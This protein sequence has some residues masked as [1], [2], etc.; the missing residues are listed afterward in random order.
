MF[1]KIINEI[2]KFNKIAIFSHQKSDGDAIG[3]S[4]ALKLALEKLGKSVEIFIQKPIHRNFNFLGVQNYVNKGGSEKFDL[5]IS[6]D[7]PNSKRIGLYEKKFLSIKNSIAIDHHA[8]FENFAD[9]NYCDSTT[10]ST[11]LIIF[12]LITKMNI[13]LDKNIALCLYSGMATDTG[14]FNHGNMTS[15]LFEAVAKLFQ[16][17]VNF[18]LA[19]YIL[20]KRQSKNEFNLYK[21]ALNKLQLFENDKIAIVMLLSNDFAS[22]NTTPLDTFRIIDTITGIETVKLACVLSQNDNE[23]FFVSI[24]SRDEFSAQNVAKEFGGGGHIR[25]SGC[26]IWENSQTALIQVVE[27]CKKEIKRVKK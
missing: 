8:D 18:D 17:G 11:C 21:L 19:N 12:K 15:E 1:E 26:K 27:A 14:R 6:L 5:A 9:V 2:N 25:A 4:I 10:S 16:V 20:F 7:C 13:E 24:R 22:T 23:E 3:S